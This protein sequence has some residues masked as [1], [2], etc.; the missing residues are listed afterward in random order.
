MAD[1]QEWKGQRFNKKTCKKAFIIKDCFTQYDAKCFLNFSI[2][3][4]IRLDLFNVGNVK[5][6]ASLFRPFMYLTLLFKLVC[7]LPFTSSMSLITVQ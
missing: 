6:M 2:K 1:H 7:L 4:V 5:Y 3:E